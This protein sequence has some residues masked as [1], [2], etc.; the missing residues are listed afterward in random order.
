MT[1]KPKSR[2]P[3]KTAPKAPGAV[4]AKAIASVDPAVTVTVAA[5]PAKVVPPPEPEP[6][7]DW[8][9]AFLPLYAEDAFSTA[10]AAG[11]DLLHV[12]PDP[13][14][15]P[16]WSILGTLTATDAPL[17]VGRHKLGARGAF[18]G[19]LLRHR[20]GHRVLAIRGTQRWSEWLTDGL[21]APRSAH[22]IGGK[23]PDGFWDLYASMRISGA[24]LSSIAAGAPI[25]VVGHS[26]GSALATYA[27]LEL[28]RAG[29]KV[30]GVFVASPHPG[31]AAFCRAFGAAVPDHIMYA[32]RGDVV[33]RLPFWFGYS[34]VPNVVTLSAS[35]AGIT[36][37]GGLAG[38]HHIVSYAAL[39]DRSSLNSFKPLPVDKPFLSCVRL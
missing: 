3:R 10:R 38:Q 34:H 22:P 16:H 7:P 32:N 30:R 12:R 2:T 13:R 21:F 33:P 28:A 39:M 15:S 4:L 24:P 36:I 23:V 17:R 19:W 29:A 31:D 27:S 11:M 8:E 25:T 20:N 35:K 5:A 9:L 1:T 26:L 6:I 18:Y 14:L 37:S